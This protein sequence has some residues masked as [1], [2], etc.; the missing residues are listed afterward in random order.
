MRRAFGDQRM[1]DRQI[2]HALG[3]VRKERAAPAAALA[4]LFEVVETLP[5][6]AGTAEKGVQLS[7][8]RQRL[9]VELLEL[10]LVIKSIDMAHTA[11]GEDVDAAFRAG[12][13]MQ[14]G[15]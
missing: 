14:A 12:Q 13:V 6:H 9:A 3:D 2:V 11:G 15:G 7:F 4:E 8:A 5:Q 10:R 1:D